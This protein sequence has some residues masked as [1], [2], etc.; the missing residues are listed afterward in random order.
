MV[1]FLNRLKS[2]LYKKRVCLYCFKDI[3]TIPKIHIKKERCYS[4]YFLIVA[5]NALIIRDIQK[6]ELQCQN[7]KQTI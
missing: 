5:C 7:N 2:F 1:K 4:K 6:D 3:L